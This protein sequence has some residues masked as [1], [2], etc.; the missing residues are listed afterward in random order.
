M[1]GRDDLYDAMRVVAIRAWASRLA[2]RSGS[3][4][5][6]FYEGPLPEPDTPLPAAW[7]GDGAKLR[8]A[9]YDRFVEVMRTIPEA[10]HRNRALL[11]VQCLNVGAELPLSDDLVAILVE[12]FRQDSA[13]RARIVRALGGLA[14]PSEAARRVVRDALLDPDG[15]VHNTALLA[16]GPHSTGSG[17]TRPLLSYG[18]VRATLMQGMRHSEF[19]VRWTAVIA[20]LSYAP[21]A[22]EFIPVLDTLRRKDANEGVRKA[23]DTAYEIVRRETDRRKHR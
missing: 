21:E 16:L 10:T 18:E 7:S 5:G 20:L 13:L 11:A 15:R 19:G 4:K 12:C 9:F 3:L 2:G 14:A 23:A 8:A 6:P 22:A 17:V 1:E